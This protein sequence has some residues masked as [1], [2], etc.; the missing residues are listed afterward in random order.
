MENSENQ[1]GSL[2]D[3]ILAME[4][5]KQR[6]GELHQLTLQ[7]R[8]RS[9]TMFKSTALHILDQQIKALKVQHQK[10]Q[11]RIDDLNCLDDREHLHFLNI[12]RMSMERTRETVDK[13]K[14]KGF[15]LGVK[16]LIVNEFHYDQ[17]DA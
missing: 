7:E 6:T 4:P 11:T 2:L 13:S 16:D 17:G 9:G 12:R 15:S 14:A 8:E 10:C 3:E 5:T 1:S